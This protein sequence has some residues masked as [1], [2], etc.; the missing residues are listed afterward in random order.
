MHPIRII[1]VAGLALGFTVQ[2][3]AAFSYVNTYYNTD[4]TSVGIGGMRGTG[5]QS[6]TL[7]GVSGRVTG[8]YLFWHGPMDPTSPSANASVLFNGTSITGIN[9][10]ISQ[11]NNWGYVN[12]QSYRA[13]VT[14][15]VSGNGTYSLANFIKGSDVDVNGVSLYVTY[16]DG[17]AANNRDLVLFNGNDSNV[18]G[19]LDPVGW[20]VVLNGVNYTS[21]SANIRLTVSDGQDLGPDEAIYLNGS[22][23]VGIG[24]TWQGALGPDITGNGSLWD[25]KIFS[26]ASFLRVG[27]N[28]L[29][30]QTFNPA[31]DA[32]SLVVAAIDL[33]AGDA[34]LPRSAVPEPSTY[35]LLGAGLLGMLAALRR[36]RKI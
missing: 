2:S 35:G 13:D 24:S 26:I 27:T 25:E 4:W 21:G 22:Q 30:L 7:S 15:L 6:L 29:E 18:G 17:N 19:P 1:S 3:F 23:L 10:G 11:D 28:N 33:P 14:A 16:N 9:I 36:R 31:T 5:I 12:S 20:D 8:A 32:M 34:P